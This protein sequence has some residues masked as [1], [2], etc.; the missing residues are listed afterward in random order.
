MALRIKSEGTLKSSRH[1]SCSTLHDGVDM[2]LSEARQADAE[3]EN[4]LQLIEDPY[5]KCFGL[6]MIGST[7]VSRLSDKGLLPVYIYIYF[8][9][10]V[11]SAGYSEA[12]TSGVSGASSQHIG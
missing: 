11:F 10:S 2:L 8:I 3:E 6:V 12:T 9:T 4:L 7:H 1:W 5:N